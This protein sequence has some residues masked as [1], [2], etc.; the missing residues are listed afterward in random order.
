MLEISEENLQDAI[1][2]QCAKMCRRQKNSK[3]GENMNRNKYTSRHRKQ[4]CRAVNFQPVFLFFFALLVPRFTPNLG[5][6]EKLVY[7]ISLYSVKE[8]GSALTLSQS[9][10]WVPIATLGKA[11][12]ERIP[13]I[14]TS[15]NSSTL[16]KWRI[17]ANYSQFHT[18]K[19][20]A[21]ESLLEPKTGKSLVFV[22]PW[23]E[24]S[25]VVRQVDHSNWFI[26]YVEEDSLLQSE[27]R[28]SFR[29]V[30]ERGNTA[31]LELTEVLLEAWDLS[32][33]ETQIAAG[34]S[35]PNISG[36]WPG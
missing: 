7:T 21:L 23:K 30:T 11:L 15:P 19:K 34:P 26:P 36:D 5:A 2:G 33:V 1:D 32:V 35:L 27:A 22:L 20:A 24:R 8:R 13:K 6:Q 25:F 9:D 31:Q 10:G 29:V 16:R 18:E 3:I 14:M 4:S 28:V 12:F 17:R